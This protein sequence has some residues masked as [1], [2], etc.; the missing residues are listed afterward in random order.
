MIVEWSTVLAL[1]STGS[2]LAYTFGAVR[3]RLA[4]L[5]RRVANA[6]H[7]AEKSSETLVEIRDRVVA[8]DEWR[9]HLKS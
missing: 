7:A 6:E 3:Q 5:E 2:T 1:I 4:E 8:I 9:K